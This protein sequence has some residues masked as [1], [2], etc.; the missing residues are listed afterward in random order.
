[1]N[2]GAVLR[3]IIMLPIAIGASSA[4]IV[5]AIRRGWLTT[6]AGKVGVACLCWLCWSSRFR[7][8]WWTVIAPRH[9]PR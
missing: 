5:I 2:D 7:R 6:M 1:M 4:A 8:R 3:A 9:T